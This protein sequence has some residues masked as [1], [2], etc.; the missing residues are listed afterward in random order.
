MF[1]GYKR[2]LFVLIATW[3]SVGFAGNGSGNLIGRCDAMNECV[4]TFNGKNASRDQLCESSDFSALWIRGSGKYLFQCRRGDTAEDNTVWIVDPGTNLFTKL[5]YGRFI[6]KGS[7]EKN[8]NMRIPDKFSSRSLCH[9]IDM[10]KLDASDFA[11][12]DK[13]PSDQDDDPYCY[14]TTYLTVEGAK[15]V[16][17]T[18]LGPVKSNDSEHAVHP[19]ST[20]DRERLIRLLDTLRQWNPQP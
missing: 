4:V 14:D 7:L 8:P 20:R 2:L 13:R 5:N 15:L 12:L 10:P 1:A 11:L 16:V 6:T 3:S 9:P 17:E 18:S 19:V